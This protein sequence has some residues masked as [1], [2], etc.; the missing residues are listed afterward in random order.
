MV[1]IL[2]SLAFLIFEQPCLIEVVIV[3]E[4][5]RREQRL[6]IIEKIIPKMLPGN[7]ITGLKRLPIQDQKYSLQ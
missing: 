5:M 7:P 4:S 6:E 2:K 1:Q 3:H